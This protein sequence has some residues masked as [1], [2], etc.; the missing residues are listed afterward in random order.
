M[1]TSATT[2]TM[3]AKRKRT[4]ITVNIRSIAARA[5]PAR[6]ITCYASW[7]VKS[8]L[9]GRERLFCGGRLEQVFKFLEHRRGRL[10]AAVE[11]RSPILR[12]LGEL[13]LDLEGGAFGD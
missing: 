10:A 12:D 2:S 1:N 5:S 3:I 11:S 13:C 9:V 7:A 8:G 4:A 6:L